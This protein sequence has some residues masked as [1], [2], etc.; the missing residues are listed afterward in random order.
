[1]DI[2][3][4]ERRGPASEGGSTVMTPSEDALTSMMIENEI[5]SRFPAIE[6]ALSILRARHNIIP[7]ESGTI[8]KRKQEIYLG[9]ELAIDSTRSSV[10]SS[11]DEN[12]STLC[13]NVV[14]SLRVSLTADRQQLRIGTDVYN[15]I[16]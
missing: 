5:L 6:K 11:I 10:R 1:M 8:A 4:D 7:S 2:C 13:L 12:S 16:A 15:Q 3:P 14:T 9:K